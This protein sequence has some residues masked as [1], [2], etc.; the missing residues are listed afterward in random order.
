MQQNG[1]KEYFVLE[2]I[3]GFNE[4]V[5]SGTI[6]TELK[7]K[8]GEISEATVG[9]LLRRLDERGWTEKEGFRGRVLTEEGKVALEKLREENKRKDDTTR[10]LELTRV[11]EKEELINI[12][13]ARRAIER[14][15]A[16]LAA[17]KATEK[18]VEG[19]TEI[20]ERNL[21]KIKASKPG[22]DEDV[23][24]HK[25]LAEIADNKF[26]EVALDL[27]RQEGQLSPILEY[28]RQRVGSAIVADHKMVLDAIARGDAEGAERAMVD[29]IEGIIADV[30]KYWTKFGGKGGEKGGSKGKGS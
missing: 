24:F 15:I 26:L 11:E 8:V 27:I 21:G 20:I 23:A 18:D 25:F 17:E 12:L 16:R 3:D 5:G 19:L 4:P 14:E 30:D 7:R 29:H 9:R 13:I 6:S 10:F 22:A 2:I 1:E 28:V